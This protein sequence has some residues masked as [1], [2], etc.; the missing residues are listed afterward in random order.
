MTFDPTKPVQTRDGRPA[1][2]VC[3]DVKGT[4]HS[5]VSL[6]TTGNVEAL[7]RH[8]HLGECADE[9][10]SNLDLVNAPRKGRVQV[11]VFRALAPG[12]APEVRASLVAPGAAVLVGIVPE[13]FERVA[14][15]LREFTEGEGVEPR[16]RS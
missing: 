10:R 7:V 11:E 13:G 1:R 12:F 9:G 3:T 6:V 15:F 8:N 5:I 4:T 2:I 14:L 16:A